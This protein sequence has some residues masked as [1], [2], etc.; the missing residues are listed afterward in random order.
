MTAY[1]SSTF[2]KIILCCKDHDA[3]VPKSA[4][5]I[6]KMA[7]H[8]TL[9]VWI[10]W[11]VLNILLHDTKQYRQ[12]YQSFLN[13]FVM[14][15]F[16]GSKWLPHPSSA[17]I[18]AHIDPVTATSI[19]TR[20]KIEKERI[21]FIK[22]KQKRWIHEF[23]KV[24]GVPSFSERQRRPRPPAN[25]PVSRLVRLWNIASDPWWMRRARCLF[26]RAFW[27]G[28][29]FCFLLIYAYSTIWSHSK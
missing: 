8:A 11:F 29:I 25:G 21:T 20:K 17:N 12:K 3:T 19:N 5:H 14:L 6:L 2:T 10:Q 24:R 26:R 28:F 18:S 7:A 16:S 15:N 23:A 9:V 22:V 1:Q 27:A 13:V 4:S